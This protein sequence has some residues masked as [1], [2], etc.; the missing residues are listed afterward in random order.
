MNNNLA[1]I[2]A[3]EGSK[4]II[5][6]NKKIFFGKPIISYPIKTLFKSKIFKKIYVSTDSKKIASI[7]KKYNACVPLL[8]AKNLANNQ[9][10]TIKVIKDFVKKNAILPNTIICCVYP[11]SPLLTATLIKK[12]F[13]KF[14]IKK[15]NF[16]IPVQKA[17][18]TD[19]NIFSLNK[20][21][22]IIQKNNS[23]IYYKDTG[24]FYFGTAKNFLKMDSILFSGSSE[25]FILP[26]TSALDVNTLED[27]NK[28]KKMFKIRQN[29]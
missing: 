8:R 3:R 9:T 11:V 28:L 16:L 1:L 21:N 26:E 19:K 17:K 29:D 10:S 22:Q 24:Q 4:R 13:K 7:A 15:N 18:L 20:K 12:A 27:W 6:K 5:N 23:N 2:I 25:V 14:L